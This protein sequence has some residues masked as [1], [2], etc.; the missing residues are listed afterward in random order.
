MPGHYLEIWHSNKYPSTLRAVL[1]SGLFVEGW[2]VYTEKVMAD[3]GYIDGDPLFRL[4]Q[5]K[6]YLR[7]I[8]NAILDQARPRRRHEPRNEAMKLMVRPDLPAGTRGRRQVDARAADLG[9][10]ADLFRRRAGAPRPAQGGGGQAT[11]TSST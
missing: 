8:A 4:V 3:A 7:A 5:L 9:A 2:A 1:R 11:A 10:A 6:W